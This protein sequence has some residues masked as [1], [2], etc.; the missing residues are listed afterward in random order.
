M[1]RLARTG[2]TPA[3]WQ[4]TLCMLWAARARGVCG[5]AWRLWRGVAALVFHD[6]LGRSSTSPGPACFGLPLLWQPWGGNRLGQHPVS[7]RIGLVC[8]WVRRPPLAGRK[9]RHCPRTSPARVCE[10][11]L[12][13]TGRRRPMLFCVR[14][15]ATLHVFH[16]FARSPLRFLALSTRRSQ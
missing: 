11:R 16:W 9:R 10:L 8:F 2:P 4:W 13:R 1:L 15:G 12:V 6:E 7:D 5:A 14:Q 3:R